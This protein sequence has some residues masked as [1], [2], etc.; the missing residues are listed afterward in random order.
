MGRPVIAI[1]GPAGSGKSTLARSIA[2]I[3]HLPYVNTGSMYR[4]VTL[5]GLR[6][7][8]D[9]DDGNALAEAARRIRFELG[10]SGDVEALLI[11]GAEPAAELASAEVERHVSGVSAHP[12]VRRV[13][14][15]EQ[16]RLGRDGAVME[17]RD[18]GSVVFPDA[19]VKLYLK[20]SPAERAARRVRER[21]EGSGG[22]AQARGT[23]SDALARA[24][25]ER[26]ERDERVNPFVPPA[27]AVALDTEGKD[28]QVVLEEAIALIRTRL[29]GPA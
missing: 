4:A 16:R 11:D 3:L 2:R 10:S 22:A 21:T 8:L 7:G 25:A 13:L 20:A 27:G 19:A 18:I 6:R 17:G 5:E 26:D 12:Q 28:P 15:R 14:R 23:G 9:L 29:E 24:L 1:D